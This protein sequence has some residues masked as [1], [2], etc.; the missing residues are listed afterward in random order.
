L[1]S[2]FFCRLGLY[3]ANAAAAADDDDDADLDS[4]ATGYHD[5]IITSV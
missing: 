1:T 2:V 3:S 4:V 5:S